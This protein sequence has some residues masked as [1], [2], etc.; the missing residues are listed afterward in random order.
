MNQ[1]TKKFFS[2]A[3]ALAIGLTIVLFAWK[4][5]ALFGGKVSVDTKADDS[6]KDSLRVVPQSSSTQ[7][8]R[9]R[10]ANI[11]E[12]KGVIMATTST[13]LLARDIL[14]NYALMQKNDPSA[15]LSDADAEALAQSLI[16]N[17]ELPK[18]TQYVLIDLNIV[19]DNSNAAFGVYVGKILSIMQAP[20]HDQGTGEVTVFLNAVSANDSKKIDGLAVF[21]AEYAQAKKS[22]LA[23]KTPSG[24]ASLHLRLVQNYANIENALTAMQK[25]FSDPVQG[26]VGF[27]Q[28]KKEIEAMTVIGVDYQ[29]YKPAR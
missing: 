10:N 28:Y 7:M 22:L 20:S 1:Q 2:I 3:V 21:I 11:S 6:W 15:M 12:T 24:I 29:N 13:S 23:V 27:A 25:V 14:A 9:V 19:S 8:L 4:G 26:L 17:V 16:K 18:A 5:G